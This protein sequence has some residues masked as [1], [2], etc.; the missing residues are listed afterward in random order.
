MAPFEACKSTGLVTGSGEVCSNDAY[1]VG[2]VFVHNGAQGDVD[3][4]VTDGDGNVLDFISLIQALHGDSR[5]HNVPVPVLAPNGINV[6]LLD[7]DTSWIVYYAEQYFHGHR[8][9]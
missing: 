7:E 9:V 3:V 5:P 1:Y 8:H 6:I 2:I 4:T